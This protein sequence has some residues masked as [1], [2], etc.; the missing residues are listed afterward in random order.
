DSQTPPVPL[1]VVNKL[2]DAEKRDQQWQND[3]TVNEWRKAPG[4]AGTLGRF[5]KKKTK[6]N[7][8]KKEMKKKAQQQCVL[9]ALR[10]T[11]DDVVAVVTELR[12]VG[13]LFAS[14]HAIC[15]VEEFE[16]RKQ[17]GRADA[18]AALQPLDRILFA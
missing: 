16:R 9:D 11:V 12:T 2:D 18:D 15:M 8:K 14:F 7:K 10:P 13:D 5:G 17:A 4:E 1:G 3:A 6:K